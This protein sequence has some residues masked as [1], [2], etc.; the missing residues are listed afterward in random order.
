MNSFDVSSN[1]KS[2]INV[3][4]AVGWINKSSL[5]SLLYRNRF[6][7]PGDPYFVNC[8]GNYYLQQMSKRRSENP[9]EWT[10]ASK[11]IGW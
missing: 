9:S 2:E 10:E 8:L 11:S 7:Q 1:E 6:A 5:R 4:E 3:P